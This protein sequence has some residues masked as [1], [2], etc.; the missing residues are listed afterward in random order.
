MPQRRLLRFL[1][2]AVLGLIAGFIALAIAVAVEPQVPAL[3]I[4]L[5]SPGMK[6]AE[7]VAPET[8]KSM[9]WTF[10]WFLR[11]AITVNAAFYL[12]IFSLFAFAMGRRSK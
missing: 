8:H 1:L 4:A 11:I 2:L 9:A 10:G 6:V 7:L 12:A 3:L 5:F